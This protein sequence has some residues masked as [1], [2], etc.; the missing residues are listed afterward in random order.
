MIISAQSIITSF[1]DPIKEIKIIRNGITP[2]VIESFLTPQAYI[3]K[4]I[5][6]RLHIAIPTY[7][8]K[9]SKKKALDPASS[10]KLIRLISIIKKAKEIFSESETKKWLYKEIPSLGN[11]KPIDLLDTDIGHRLVEQ[12]LQQIKFGIYA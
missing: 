7:K 3:M 9:K 4:D 6:E 11:Q 10:E 1:D 12:T 8:A 5:L 2:D